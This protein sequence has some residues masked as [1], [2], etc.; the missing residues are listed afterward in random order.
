MRK[1]QFILLISCCFFSAV[2]ITSPSLAQGSELIRDASIITPPA[3]DEGIIY[4]YSWSVN[5]Y[6]FNESAN[7]LQWTCVLDPPVGSII[8]EMLPAP[9]PIPIRSNV[10]L[11]VGR[12]LW[13]ISKVDGH[14]VWSVNNL[15]EGSFEA[16]NR[17]S[18]RLPGFYAIDEGNFGSVLTLEQDQTSSS[19]SINRRLLGDGSLEWEAEIDGV[20]RGWW[21]NR[22]G[23]FLAYESDGSGVAMKIDPRTGEQKWTS[24]MITGASYRSS[25][26]GTGR[27]FLLQKLDSGQFEIDAY[28]Q[29]SGNIYK[30]IT[31][32]AGELIDV[33]QSDDKLAFMHR[34]G[35]ESDRQ[36]KFLL[37]YTSLNPIRIQTIRESRSDQPFSVPVIEGNLLL[38][39]GR[40]YSVF[41]GNTVWSKNEQ[42]SLIYTIS[43]DYNIYIWEESGL[44][45][46]WDR[47]TGAENWSTQLNVNLAQSLF[48]PNYDGASMTLLDGRLFIATPSGELFRMNIDTGELYPGV[49]KVSQSSRTS[50]TSSRNSTS[51]NGPGPVWLWFVL[52]IAAIG[53]LAWIFISK[54]KAPS[55]GTQTR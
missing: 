11:H 8:P 1:L 12:R 26:M 48:N 13:G 50:T 55:D 7:E 47:L 51:P 33:L 6:A 36:V 30:T 35:E 14:P 46:S 39:A 37:Y 24:D 45:S 10:L 42:M 54:S 22:E 53:L 38:Y 27:I 52:V 19:W 17:A 28:N 16:S 32:E 49:I 4:F 20:P 15:P 5:L 44:I 9:A 21:F 18:N 25:F 31:Y 29:D 23:L 40:A 34:E 3:I 2:F 41:D 43:D